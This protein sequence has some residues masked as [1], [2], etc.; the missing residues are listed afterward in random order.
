MGHTG[1]LTE[2]K[3]K[4]LVA[5]IKGVLFCKGFSHSHRILRPHKDIALR[6]AHKGQDHTPC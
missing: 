4:Y 6:V 2:V 5:L 3:F 1:T